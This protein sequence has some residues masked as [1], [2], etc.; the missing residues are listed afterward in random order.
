MSALKPC[1][2]LASR[3]RQRFGARGGV[4]GAR[5]FDTAQTPAFSEGES[6]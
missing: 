5:Y 4:A 6:L 1:H 3:P 2:A